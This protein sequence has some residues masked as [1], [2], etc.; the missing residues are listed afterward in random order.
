MDNRIRDYA[1]EIAQTKPDW[2][3]EGRELPVYKIPISKLFYNDD[4]GRIATWIS[5]YKNDHGE[6]S[7]NE[8]SHEEFN[9][10]IHEYIKKSNSSD[11][12]NK[13]YKDIYEKGQ[14]R[15]G[16]VLG[17]GRVVSG[18]RRFTVLRELFK[19]TGS[20][21]FAYFECFIVEKALDNELERKEIKTIE[22]LTQFG[23]DEKV[24]YDPIDRLVD[25][26]NDLIGPRK[27]F[28]QLEYQHKLK[29]KKS[30]A[31][32]MYH[33]ARFMADYLQ[34]IGKPERFFIARAQKLD[35][36]LQELANHFKNMQTA[37]WNRIRVVF[38]SYFP[39]KGDTTRNIR[40]LIKIYKNSRERFE[41]LLNK[42]V[43]DI[44]EIEKNSSSPYKNVF[45]NKQS[46][47]FVEKEDSGI[48][49]AALVSALPNSILSK[50]TK[51]ATFVIA[52]QI[53]TEKDRSDKIKKVS[54]ALDTICFNL[55]DSMQVANDEEIVTM[56]KKIRAAK[57]IIVQIFEE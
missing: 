38:Y 4:N 51:D 47:I 49:T 53:K 56:R 6:D 17:D 16:V 19:N 1:I 2:S 28:T 20:D 50:D 13:T 34:F 5:E 29:L 33:K 44:E 43:S 32:R 46:S 42:V 3:P 40:E 48:D 24:D 26:Y 12:F 35:G 36:P 14:I 7:L 37:E 55:K 23:V 18:N 10:L 45:E 57:Q 41:V 8:L 22:R 25:V 30:D 39:E 54:E 21:K 9:D 52:A 15:P 31:D 11:S 27:I